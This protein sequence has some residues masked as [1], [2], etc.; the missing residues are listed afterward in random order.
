MPYGRRIRIKSKPS[1]YFA[2]AVPI[3]NPKARMTPDS[4]R[5]S[6]NGSNPSWMRMMVTTRA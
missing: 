5:N 3:I 1:K 2:L 4:D 6:A